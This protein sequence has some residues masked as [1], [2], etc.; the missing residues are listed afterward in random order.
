MTRGIRLRA[1]L[2][3]GLFVLAIAVLS[4]RADAY[5][6]YANFNGNQSIG[7]MSLSGAFVNPDFIPNARHP[8]GVA[9]DGEHIFWGNLNGNRG[10]PPVPGGG[11][12]RANLDGSGV[13]QDLVPN[14]DFPC[15]VAINSTYVYWSNRGNPFGGTP[16][17]SI[18]R[19]TLDGGGI[20]QTF[21]D[22]LNAP[23]GVAVDGSHIYWGNYLNNSI[24]RANL[25]GLNVELDFIEGADAP[26][27]VAVDGAHV[28]WTN[29]GFSG[30]NSA[31]YDGTT[32]GRANLDGTGVNPSF[33][34][35]G[36]GPFGIAVHA[37]HLYWDTFFDFRIRRATLG[38]GG[39]SNLGFTANGAGVAVDSGSPRAFRFGR[40]RFPRPGLASIL[41]RLP[42]P[43]A[44]MLRGRGIRKRSRKLG[45]ASNS[46]DVRLLVRPI[47]GARQTLA[48]TGKVTVRAKVTFTPLGGRRVTHT[49]RV[50]LTL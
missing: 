36:Q 37:S 18:G 49:R 38:G 25:N 22:T 34:T 35:T 2:A 12:G 4:A 42:G 10:G 1:P 16:G 14:A 19:A 20:D 21:I 17:D 46:W 33:I 48:N 7:R 27:G 23:C 47:G 6:Y 44:L 40:T 8:C 32:I 15:G 9:V 26:C 31:P 39:I 50:R 3:G 24:G 13:N 28:Y 41:V 45:P 5:V 43:G 11:I 30:N 29:S